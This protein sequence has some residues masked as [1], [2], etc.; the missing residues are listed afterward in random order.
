VPRRVQAAERLVEGGE[1][2][3][4]GMVGEEGDE[5]VAPA[6]DVVDEPLERLLRADL[7]EGAHALAPERLEAADPLDR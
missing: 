2:A 5:P 1:L 7:D 6:E 3:D 4:L